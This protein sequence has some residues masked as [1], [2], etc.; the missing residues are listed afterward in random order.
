M[1]DP[2]PDGAKISYFSMDPTSKGNFF[3]LGLDLNVDDNV[4]LIPNLQ[5]VTYAD[6]AID[7]DVFLKTT[8]S[9]TF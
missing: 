7:S 2:V 9:V 5:L 4:H 6:A 1:I 8:F 3:L